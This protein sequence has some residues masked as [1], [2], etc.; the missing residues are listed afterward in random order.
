MGSKTVTAE[1]DK[2]IEV[3]FSE[4]KTEAVKTG[5]VQFSVT[6]ENAVMY[7]DGT[8]VD[9]TELIQLEY[10]K[11][12]VVLNANNYQTYTETFTVNASYVKKII[13]M[14][15][16]STS[17]TKSSTTATKS[18]TTTTKSSTMQA[19]LT[20]GYMVQVK[21]P[22]GAAVYV[23]SV[24]IGI[25]PVSFSKSAGKKVVTVTKSGCATKSYTIEIANATGDLNY[26]FPD[27]E[28][29]TTTATTE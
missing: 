13:D 27:M 12:T 10:G 4:F 26:S 2:S 1:R 11:H 7:I 17:T 14:S 9:D 24:Y 6:P 29:T 20:S 8:Q 16:T 21:A 22:E 15:S 5:A 18:S 19:D 25:A 23:D 28:E 3:D